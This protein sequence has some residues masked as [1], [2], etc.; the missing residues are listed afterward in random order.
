MRRW[1][2]RISRVVIRT[3]PIIIGV[4]PGIRIPPTSEE[5]SAGVPRAITGAA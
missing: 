3:I 1:I 2:I 5:D 4:A